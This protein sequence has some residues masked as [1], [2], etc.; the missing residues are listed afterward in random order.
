M[1]SGQ[2]SETASLGTEVLFVLV[3]NFCY[4]NSA[5]DNHTVR[6]LVLFKALFSC[7]PCCKLSYLKYSVNLNRTGTSFFSV[8]SKIKNITVSST[9][10]TR[11][12]EPVFMKDV[13]S[14]LK[15]ATRPPWMI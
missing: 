12:V 5:S 11:M 7:E 2:C 8:N 4:S 13:I 14:K 6:N 15:V 3:K 1:T 10:I 9:N